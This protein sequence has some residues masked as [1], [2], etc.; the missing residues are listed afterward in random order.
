MEFSGCLTDGD[1]GPGVQGCRE[2]FDFTLKFEKIFLSIL[3]AAIFISLS[4]AR[5]AL[6]ARWPK[7]VGGT[8]FQVVKVVRND[9]PLLPTAER[10]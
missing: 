9:L 2:D 3:P 7:V 10:T 6:L 1:F 5:T 8:W 4:I